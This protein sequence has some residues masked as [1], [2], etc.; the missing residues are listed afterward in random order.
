MP[1]NLRIIE[2]PTAPDTGVWTRISPTDTDATATF[3]WEGAGA[4][5]PYNRLWIHEGGHDYYQTVQ[6]FALTVWDI[7]N[8]GW[9]V[10]FPDN[11]PPGS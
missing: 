10:K 1:T 11:G 8:G 9:T 6:S 3:G 5:D 2:N 4:Y 7:D